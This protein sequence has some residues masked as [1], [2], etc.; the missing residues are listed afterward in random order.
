M[1]AKKALAALMKLPEKHKLSGE[2]KE[3]VAAA[4]GALDCVVLAESK[5]RGYIAAKKSKR[6][7]SEKL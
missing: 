7:R 4:V 3:A 5:L 1:E 2:E 6:Q